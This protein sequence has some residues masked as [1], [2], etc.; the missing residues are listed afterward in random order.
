MKH[1]RPRVGKRSAVRDHPPSNC[2]LKLHVLAIGLSAV[3]LSPV[4]YASPALGSTAGHA[5]GVHLASLKSHDNLAA[6]A[7]PAYIGT[8]YPSTCPDW[9]AG[10]VANITVNGNA[11]SDWKPSC[12]IGPGY[13]TGDIELA[14]IQNILHALGYNDGGRDSLYGP[15]T[16]AGIKLFQTHS[17]ITSDGIVGPTTWSHFGDTIYYSYTG[18]NAWN[19]SVGQDP[20]RFAKGNYTGSDGRF[21]PWSTHCGEVGFLFST[22][23]YPNPSIPCL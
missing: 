23:S 20:N 14:G 10:L 17:G 6:P 21:G 9:P 19:Y 2:R 16:E 8:K 22:I 13:I 18:P 4:L 11:Q 12:W 7:L 5:A 1:V 15:N 3:L